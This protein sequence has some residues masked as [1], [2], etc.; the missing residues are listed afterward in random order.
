MIDWSPY[1]QRIVSISSQFDVARKSINAFKETPEAVA[2]FIENSVKDL[3]D[4]IG[5]ALK[6]REDTKDS[7]WV[8]S[9]EGMNNFVLEQ[10]QLVGSRLDEVDNRLRQNELIL[11]VSVLES[12][13]KDIHREILRQNPKYLRHDRKIDLGKIVSVGAEDIIREEIEREVHALDRKNLEERV[14][15]FKDVLNIKLHPSGVKFAKKAFELRNRMLHE[16]PDCT[17]SINDV[18][19]ALMA[20]VFLP[21]LCIVHASVT[22]PEGFRPIEGISED[23]VNGYIKT[24]S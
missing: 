20:S 3:K 13:M 11:L 7:P 2:K 21:M 9:E 12:F 24:I 4:A 15:Y 10:Q 19:N 22:Y 17:V 16:D 8:M 5:D 6:K 14:V 1:F 23:I 18:A